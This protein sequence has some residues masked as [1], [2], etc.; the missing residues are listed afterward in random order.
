MH[1]RVPRSDGDV[2]TRGGDSAGVHAG[3]RVRARGFAGVVA[4][5]SEYEERVLLEADSLPEE[6]I[7]GLA[8]R[9]AARLKGDAWRAYKASGLTR[10]D[11]KTPKSV[12][13]LVKLLAALRAEFGPVK[14]LLKFD[15]FFDAIYGVQQKQDEGVGGWRKRGVAVSVLMT[16][17]FCIWTMYFWQILLRKD[18][19]NG[20]H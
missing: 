16:I 18:P 14:E 3:W 10:E 12:D 2:G 9:I 7:G 15:H 5:W 11:I 1:D 19:S 13:G 20:N 4:T 6:K 8:P 17:P